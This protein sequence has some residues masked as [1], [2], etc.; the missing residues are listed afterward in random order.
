MIGPRLSGEAEEKA[1]CLEAWFRGRGPVLVAY[2]GGVDSALVAV[3]A[4]RVLGAEG[5][6]AV[7]ADSPSLPRRELRAAMRFA[8]DHDVPVRAVPTREVEREG[9]AA[10][11]GDRCYFCKQELYTVLRRTFSEGG[12]ETVVNGTNAD[13]VDEWR[14]GLRA[15]EELDVESPLLACGL[16][17][18]EIRVVSRAWG[19][20]TW[21]KPA[22][23]CLASRIPPGTTVTSERLQRVER[24]EEVLWDEGFRVFRVRHH[25]D[26]ARLEVAEEERDRLGDAG[27]R[28]RVFEGVRGAGYAFVT[29]DLKPY[30]S[31]RLS[32]EA[33]GDTSV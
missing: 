27:L 23:A 25:G 12:W 5:V 17:K 31:G 4:R 15:A 26:L 3:A 19:L 18:E 1:R 10:N 7:V 24:A 20:E 28:H 6:L 29:V 13:D 22:L 32:E 9:Y 11:R 2:S 8:A 21:D 14:P 33:E 30:R 16:G